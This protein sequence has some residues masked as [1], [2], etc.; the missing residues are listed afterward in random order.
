MLHYL[1]KTQW[2]YLL[3]ILMKISDKNFPEKEAD[4]FNNQ[5]QT[6][7]LGVYDPHKTLSPKIILFLP[8]WTASKNV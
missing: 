4:H 6:A 7:I 2:N 1:K 3:L 5:K 8:Y